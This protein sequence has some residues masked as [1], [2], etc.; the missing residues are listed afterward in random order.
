MKNKAII[1]SLIIIMVGIIALGIGWHKIFDASA[2]KLNLIESKA[3]ID[4]NL[5]ILCDMCDSIHS[6]KDIEKYQKVEDKTKRQHI[7]V[8]KCAILR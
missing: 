1:T 4:Q 5:D 2:T 6:F 7:T 3:Y 8:K